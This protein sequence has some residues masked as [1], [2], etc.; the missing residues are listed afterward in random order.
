MLTGGQHGDVGVY[1]GGGEGVEILEEGGEV[2]DGGR[3]GVDFL[4]EGIYEAGQKSA[5]ALS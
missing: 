4:R 1:V 5:Y 3:A 2:V